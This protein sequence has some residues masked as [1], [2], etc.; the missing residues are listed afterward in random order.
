MDDK[1]YEYEMEAIIQPKLDALMECY[2]LLMK[3]GVDV[4]ELPTPYADSKYI[5]RDMVEYYTRKDFV[6]G[7]VLQNLET[8]TGKS[9][10][11]KEKRDIMERLTGR[12]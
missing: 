6:P 9:H 3:L 7:I 5:L 11:D 12:L 2:I 1:T 8:I 10:N 4:D